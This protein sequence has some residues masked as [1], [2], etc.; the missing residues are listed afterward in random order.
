M[1]RKAVPQDGWLHFIGWDQANRVYLWLAVVL[2]VILWLVFKIVYP[3]PNLIFDSYYYVRAAAL[4]LNV[5]AWPIGYSKVIEFFGQF[6]HSVNWLLAAQFFFLQ[7]SCG[8]FFFTW[9]TIFR[10]GRLMSNIVFVLLFVNPIFFYCC[11]YILAEALFIGCSLIWLTL[12][13]WIIVRPRP[14]MVVAHAV[15]LLLAFSIRYNAL[16]YPLVGALAFLF[17]RQRVGLKIA[18]I[19]L[20]LVLLGCFMYYTASQVAAVTG[21]RQFAP[22]GGWKLANDALYMY[23]HVQDEPEGSAGPV[24]DRFRA[25]DA[26][27]RRYFAASRDTFDM[28]NL[29]QTSGSTFMF[30]Y[31]SP[32]VN[33]MDSVYGQKGQ[34]FNS[35]RWM[36]ISPLYQ[37]YGSWLIRKYPM[38]FARYFCWPNI[39]RYF[40]PPAENFATEESYYLRPYLGGAYLQQV[41]GLTAIPASPGAIAWSQRILR[42][43][44]SL[45]TIFH[46]A[47]ILGL[48]GFIFTG[49]LKRAEGPFRACIGLIAG[50]WLIDFGFSVLSAGIV[51]RYQLF[52]MIPEMAC[53][54][55]FLSYIYRHLDKDVKVPV[56]TIHQ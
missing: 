26:T 43:Y 48:A 2:P 27:V 22:F 21:K 20:P 32:L 30:S 9:R 15:V 24:P 39:V 3:Y 35:P 42:P 7:L 46:L 55:Y 56:Q 37:S 19:V 34:P 25:L 1:V 45:L 16:Y 10:P 29:D 44:P 33:Y 52:V 38:A 12:L 50:L 41:F 11:N 14:W 51:L 47:F 54:I 23:A 31:D 18:G 17:S 28:L 5:N 49:G 53:S 6:P 4:D 36:A 8:F 40:A 13:L